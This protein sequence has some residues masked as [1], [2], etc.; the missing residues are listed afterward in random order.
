MR[1]P[2]EHL[3]RD[4]LEVKGWF[5]AYKWLI[6]RRASQIGILGLF[7]LGPFAGLWL[8][9]GTLAQSLLLDVVPLTDPLLFVQILASGFFEIGTTT[10]IGAAI[11]A[12]FYFLIGGR[13]FCSWACPVNIVADTALWARRRLGIRQSA[14]LKPSTRY[15]VLG[16]T[17]IV[18]AVTG[19]LAY[20][21]V[22]PV[23]LAHRSLIF[24][25]GIGWLALAAVFLFD[26][27][28]MRHG[29]CGHLCPMGAFYG[30]IGARSL[31]RIRADNRA[32]CDD[33]MECYEVCPEPQ[34]I[35]PAVK[36]LASG[37]SPVIL[38]G[39]CT[40]CARCIDICPNHVFAFGLRFGSQAE[41]EPNDTGHT[42]MAA[43]SPPPARPEQERLIA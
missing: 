26:L 22:N 34:V 5:G 19:T 38:D 20:E 18:S 21:L 1:T 41:A 14:R 3:G 11:V 32:A 25:F 13:V 2:I 24:G 23:S 4:A 9:K 43:W 27:L 7:L 31:V 15:W 6:L 35:P 40:N 33:C 36:S 12:A 8:I 37:G 10:V 30:L 17:L 16:L 28:V 42:G 29:W 39:N